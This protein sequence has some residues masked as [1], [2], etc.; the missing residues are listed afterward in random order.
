VVAP[1]HAPTYSNLAF[2]LLAYALENI[3]ST[4]FDEL[5]NATLSDLPLNSTYLNVPPTPDNAVIPIN[6]TTSW[7]SADLGPLGPGGSF[8]STINDLRQFG[9]SILNSTVLTP[10]QTRRWLKPHSFSPDTYMTV[11]APWEIVPYPPDDRFPTR[12]Y[13]KAGGIGLYSA[14][15][16]LIPDYNIG[17]TILAAGPLSGVVNAIGSD[18]ISST[19][20]TA[21]KAAA[22]EQTEQLYAG[23]YED[24]AT[25]STLALSVVDGGDGG[26]GLH[27]DAWTWKG[28]DVIALFG[29]LLGTNTSIFD[30][31][32]NLL[33][34]GLTGR[35]PNGTNLVSWR[36]TY[37]IVVPTDDSLDNST[38]SDNSTSEDTSSSTSILSLLG[39]FSSACFSWAT[40]D[41][42]SYAAVSFDEVV[43]AVDPQ[44]GQV[45][46]VEMRVLR[47]GA[48]EKASSGSGN[49]R[50][51]KRGD[52]LRTKMIKRQPPAS[53]YVLRT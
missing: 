42:L 22:Q 26:P 29:S 3:T 16:G 21:V 51:V 49:G 46:S 40:V 8:Y 44:S 33:P 17:F 4:P 7:Y 36:G 41:A 9:L 45:L 15:M 38:S 27:I 50:L 1:F 32:F 28:A 12:I 30:L 34:T 19:F 5:V 37:A 2:Q 6:D 14:E 39:P 23:L 20:I 24:E 48:L 31:E 47:S 10:S 18:L 11:G 52:A 35:G 53:P 25:N 43:F 13:A